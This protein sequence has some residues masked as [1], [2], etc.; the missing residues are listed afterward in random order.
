MAQNHKR[1]RS[2][3]NNASQV[4]SHSRT[5]SS[6]SNAPQVNAHSR[7][8][9]S[10]SSRTRSGRLENALVC[11]QEPR[12]T[13]TSRARPSRV[14]AVHPKLSS[15][16][17]AS[18][19]ENGSG[20]GV[21]DTWQHT[22]SEPKQPQV[23]ERES[24]VSVLSVE[25]R[26]HVEDQIGTGAPVEAEP[27]MATDRGIRKGAVEEAVSSLAAATEAILA[28]RDT[29]AAPSTGATTATA[30]ATVANLA[31]AVPASQQPRR[32]D[33]ASV[34]GKRG[35]PSNKKPGKAHARLQCVPQ[36]DRMRL[37]CHSTNPSVFLYRA[38]IR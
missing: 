36:I 5:R 17:A 7:T 11:E 19:T 28:E 3:V 25:G 4:N 21:D 37:P 12:N 24:S 15:L 26:P 27:T 33:R 35:R 8:R 29:L 38:S 2:S 30:A 10:V 22:Q 34:R 18:S 23:V 31:A 14:R 32:K 9:S 16:A 6:V 1:A 20:V 13:S